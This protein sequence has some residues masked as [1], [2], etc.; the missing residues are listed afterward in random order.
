[1]HKV[2]I[3]PGVIK[4]FRWLVGFELVFTTLNRVLALF[5]VQT[6]PYP[7]WLLFM[8]APVGLAIL[9]LY[10]TLKPIPRLLGDWFLPLPL[11]AISIFPLLNQHL[12]MPMELGEM[13]NASLVAAWQMFPLLFVPFVFTTWQYRMRGVLLFTLVTTSLDLA[14][15]LQRSPEGYFSLVAVIMTRTFSF[16]LVGAILSQLVKMQMLQRRALEAANSQLLVYAAALEDLSTSRE[17]NRLARELH[18]TLAH[19]L[20]AVSV[21]LEAVKVLMEESPPQA[22]DQLD[23]VLAT[24][25]SGLTE[26]RRALQALR[27]S[28]LEDM[29]LPLALRALANGAAARAGFEVSVELPDRTDAIPGG[30]AQAIYR[31]VQESLENIVRH[32]SARQVLI[33]LKGTDGRFELV[34]EDDGSGFDMQS[35]EGSD[36]LGLRGMQER[37][38][39]LG[40]HFSVDSQPG[41]GTRVHLSWEQTS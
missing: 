36:R 22:R 27:A 40:A 41:N 11:A 38:Q 37:A 2:E 21:Q 31:T 34:I 25:R 24:T 7:H 8:L 33:K 5:V 4:I 9:L 17:R 12:L 28:P 23:D 18:D 26:T 13:K 29:G 1:M 30:V 20:T 39:V 16:L 35:V 14:L 6:I 32:A 3:D 19:T 15:T 10:L